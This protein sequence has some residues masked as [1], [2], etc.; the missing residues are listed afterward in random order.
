VSICCVKFNL[1]QYVVKQPKTVDNQKRVKYYNDSVQA[2]T[3][4]VLEDKREEA[5]KTA[6]TFIS[7]THAYIL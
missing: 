5:A 6:P 4:T 2:V 3:C 1:S 7:A